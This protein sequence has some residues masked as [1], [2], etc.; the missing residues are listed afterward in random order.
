METEEAAASSGTAAAPANSNSASSKDVRRS[1]RGKGKLE[2]GSEDK[3]ETYKVA[4]VEYTAGECCYIEDVNRGGNEPYL[5]SIIEEFRITRRDT[6][7]VH[8]RTYYRLH[9]VPDASYQALRDRESEG[10]TGCRDDL[11]PNREIKF[12]ELFISD[13]SEAFPT[14][15]LRGKC[16]VIHYPDLRSAVTNFKLEPDTFFYIFTYNPETRRLSSTKAEIHVGPSYQAELPDYQ[17]EL[18]HM[19]AIADETG[20]VWETQRWLP[21]QLDDEELSMY[22]KAA[23]SLAA[24]SGFCDLGSAQEGQTS[25]DMD[26]TAQLAMDVLHDLDYDVRLALKVLVRNPQLGES[27]G[28]TG[29]TH[30]CVRKFQKGIRQYG[31][32]FF[33]IRRE[34]FPERRV[35]QLVEFYYLWKKS[36][37]CPPSVRSVRRANNTNSSSAN[38]AAAAAA[39]AAAVG[40]ASSSTIS[41]AA[42]ATAA[43]N[44]GCNSPAPSCSS[45]SCASN[46]D[47]DATMLEDGSGGGGAASGAAAAGVGDDDNSCLTTVPANCRNCDRSLEEAAGSAVAGSGGAR[48]PLCP[49]C[50]L[51]Y[52]KYGEDRP[53]GRS[54]DEDEDEDDTSA[55]DST[56]DE[57]EEDDGRRSSSSSGSCSEVK[58]SAPG[59]AASTDVEASTV[60]TASTVQS[61]A[62]LA[63]LTTAT[64]TTSTAA[65]AVSSSNASGAAAA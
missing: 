29:W 31:K 49:E 47:D 16:S 5:I 1:N 63:K 21:D 33:R 65:A 27:A 24:F 46:K 9:D 38:A 34:L 10:F 30:E 40:A 36:S 4:G 18:P 55:D 61:S 25:A 13:V 60:A 7:N 56:E 6:T 44:G 3:I 12:R 39:S 48:D 51:F 20:R 17:S 43:S 42:A 58:S 41:A 23:R 62:V 59:P 15:W 37:S 14:A 57:E 50:R 54:D 2:R 8:V 28:P 52:Q 11:F 64:T 32:N 45:R 22:V 53:C 35:S 19:H 26:R